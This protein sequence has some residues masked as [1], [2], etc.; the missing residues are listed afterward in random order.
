[1]PPDDALVND[2]ATFKKLY[3]PLENFAT[4]WNLS[5]A[6]ELFKIIQS[7][8]FDEARWAFR[9]Q[10]DAERMLR[11]S[12]E[13]VASSPQIAEHYV[14]AEFKRRAHHY[15]RDLPD[16]EDDLEWL[17]LMQH[18]GAPTRLLDWTRSAYVGA[19]FAAQSAM[20]PKR[21]AAEDERPSKP[22]AIWAIDEKSI[23][24]EAVAMLGLPPGDNYLSSRENF[25]RIYRELQPEGLYLTAPVQP[26]RMNERLT[27]QQGLFLCANNPL[28]GLHR[29]LKSLLHYASKR[30]TS[31][32]QWLH[33]LVVKPEAR[34]DV[35][36]I[37]NKMNINRATLFPGLDGFSVSLRINTEILDQENWGPGFR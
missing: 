9:G 37:L 26:D 36:K 1:L 24:A 33:K 27:I 2:L 3:E 11:P 5:S 13:W 22:F 17:A 23:N 15:L 25:R 32:D 31:T 18:H 34:L 29:C 20:S 19:F 16:D 4:V 14:E 10:G 7:P 12:I 21:I 8:P 35:L 28:V 30:H 6:A